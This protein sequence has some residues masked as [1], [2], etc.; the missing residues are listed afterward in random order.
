MTHRPNGHRSGVWYYT[1]IIKRERS[2]TK[3]LA[4]DHYE[5]QFINFQSP[6]AIEISV[7]EVSI[8]GE[9]GNMDEAVM[10]NTGASTAVLACQRASAAQPPPS[11][12]TLSLRPAGMSVEDAEEK[13][14]IAAFQAS[15]E[16][17]MG[18]KGGGGD[19]IPIPGLGIDKGYGATFAEPGMTQLKQPTSFIRSFATTND[20]GADTNFDKL[21]CSH[22]HCA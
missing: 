5:K 11:C 22:I 12:V 14:F 4:V 17:M 1:E 6:V 10:K 16:K 20:R 2:E 9:D 13:N 18:A 21:V 19:D 7:G 3:S 15:I 8:K